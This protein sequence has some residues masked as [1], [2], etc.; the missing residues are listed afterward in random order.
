MRLSMSAVKIIVEKEKPM[1]L[2]K[3]P[4]SL[5]R[6]AMRLAA[7]ML[8]LVVVAQALSPAT[9]H[10]QAAC[11]LP[12]RLQVGDAVEV[13]DGTAN[14]LRQGPGL[15]YSKLALSMAPGDVW[16]VQQGPVCV[17]GI[18]WYRVGAYDADG[19]TAEG[20]PGRG[21]Y[22]G[23]TNR[24]PGEGGVVT[25]A[26]ASDRLSVGMR[27]IVGDGRNQRVRRQ[28][29]K[30]AREIA[31]LA[32]GVPVTLV[33]GP[34]CADGWIWWYISDD[35]GR[36][37]GW[38]AEGDGHTPWLV[39]AWD[40]SGSATAGSGSFAS[41]GSTATGS[42]GDET[43]RPKLT[44][45]IRVSP[46]DKYVSNFSEDREALSV[47]LDDFIVAT[48]PGKPQVTRRE[49]ITLPVRSGPK[50]YR[51]NLTVVGT[52]FCDPGGWATVALQVGTSTKTIACQ[53]NTDLIETPEGFL[54][55]NADLR[56]VITAQVWKSGPGAEPSVNVDLI[57][58]GLEPR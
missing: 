55:A 34:S 24:M 58:I 41:A 13:I 54:P 52:L 2:S 57:D 51:V 19:W 1:N 26:C 37:Q 11:P 50:G 49:T 21:Y 6:P 46:T 29:S 42:T 10:A 48:S 17:N 36:I 18:N 53:G 4:L 32:P 15:A 40:S 25:P 28:P 33:D 23:R 16:Y 47:F 45:V 12:A 27:V 22:L 30:A 3:N 9:S 56:I 38:T 7:V 39:P 35:S 44:G 8:L 31:W 14:W 43:L 5:R 20:Q